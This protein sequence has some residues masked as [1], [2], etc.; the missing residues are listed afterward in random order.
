MY[1]VIGGEERWT[2]IGHT[3]LL[4]VL[5]VVWGMRDASVR[6]VTALEASKTA[7]MGYLRVKGF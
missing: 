5:V 2:S 1:D 6:P 3:S 4:R 7:R